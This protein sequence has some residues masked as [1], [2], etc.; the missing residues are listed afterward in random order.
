M[1]DVLWGEG[2]DMFT[3][4]THHSYGNKSTIL[5]TNKVIE[6]F[7]FNMPLMVILGRVRSLLDRVLANP[8]TK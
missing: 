7:N 8:P 5:Q 2:Y 3:D 1:V 4:R 6:C